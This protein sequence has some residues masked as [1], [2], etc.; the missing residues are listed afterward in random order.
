MLRTGKV[1]DLWKLYVFIQMMMRKG[2]ARV[3]VL[4]SVKH[5]LQ[6]LSYP[7]H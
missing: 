2:T 6:L 3:C 4:C 7:D 5:K 1:L